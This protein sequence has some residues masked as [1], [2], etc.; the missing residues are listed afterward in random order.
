MCLAHWAKP[1][2]SCVKATRNVLGSTEPNS[3]LATSNTEPFL[4]SAA[5]AADSTV[6]VGNPD[7]E[8]A[9]NSAIFQTSKIASEPVASTT[10]SEASDAQNVTFLVDST[11]VLTA[12]NE[13]GNVPTVIE[14]GELEST[15][16]LVDP[17]PADVLPAASVAV[18]VNIRQTYPK[19]LGDVFKHLGDI[20]SS[21]GFL[22][23]F[24]GLNWRGI[25]P[26]D[27]NNLTRREMVFRDKLFIPV[28]VQQFATDR[29]SFILLFQTDSHII[30]ERLMREE[31]DSLIRH[32][33]QL[34]WQEG[35]N[36]KGLTHHSMLSFS[37][38]TI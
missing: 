25:H 9:N 11:A 32:R 4:V 18:V 12:S 28:K 27:R 26:D 10:G 7:L 23:P 31:V 13:N 17:V 30:E 33:P 21:E 36:P 6:V 20:S 29:N 15:S 34:L 24:R 37:T 16:S 22:I 14:G 38:N 1:C 3:S 5:P 2:V 35:E 19:I 8:F